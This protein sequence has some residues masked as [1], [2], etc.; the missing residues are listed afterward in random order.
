MAADPPWYTLKLRKLLDPV[1]WA[2]F[3]PLLIFKLAVF[4]FAA[5]QYLAF[6]F[7]PY[8]GLD[9]EVVEAFSDF[10]YY[11]M[12][13]VQA[14]LQG[15][16]PYT[17]ELWLYNG[18][19]TYIYPPGFLYIITGFTFIPSEFLFP[20]LIL[21]AE[22]LGRSLLFLRVGF[23]FIVFDLATCVLMYMI[24]RRLSQNRVIPLVVL[25]LYALNPISLWWGNYLWLS[26]PIHTFFMV[27]GFYFIVRGDLRWAV[28]WLTVG[29]MVKQTAALLIPVVLF[30]EFRRNSKR[31]LSSLGIVF[32]VGL[33]FSLPYI[34]IFPTV[35]AEALLGGLSPY[36][37]YNELPYQTFPIPISILAYYWIEPFKFIV[38]NSVFLGIPF[39]IC[40]VVFWLFALFIPEQPTEA[41]LKPLLS[42]VLLL[43]LSM[44][45][46]LP[47]GIYKFYLIALLPFLILFGAYLRGP[48]IPQTIGCP[49]A[50]RVQSNLPYIPS[51]FKT[52]LNQ[53]REHGIA[54]LNNVSTW[55]FVLVAI[56]SIGIFTVHRYYTHVILLCFFLTLLV[57][58]FYRYLWVKRKRPTP[59]NSL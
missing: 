14:F 13:F 17:D 57:Y 50:K 45:L 21:E 33:V 4:G 42:L 39:I 8:F 49:L 55:W 43:S 29:A 26:T 22:S 36:W 52:L 11:Y 51:P 41:C 44:H 30:L 23:S 12:N 38:Y 40:L 53:L 28:L 3:I 7:H 56:A 32:V 34:V 18:V 58:S 47:R 6:G 10:S 2:G 31:F 46:F 27:M 48:L 5:Q 24:A 37:L 59:P 9:F 25:V 1:F 54:I 15:H 20:N 35:Y 19:Q 16:L